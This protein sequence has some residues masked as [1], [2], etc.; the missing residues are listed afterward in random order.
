MSAHAFIKVDRATFFKFAQSHEGRCEYVRGRIIMQ[1]GGTFDHGRIAKR[2]LKLLD[3]QL[4]PQKWFASGSDR[5]VETSVTVRYPDVTVE[6]AGADPGSLFTQQ[7]VIAIEVL[8]PS[9][10]ERDL[11]I[12]PL[13]YLA[14]PTLQAYIVAA[15]DDAACLVWLR[16]DDGTFP[17]EP[18]E[19]KGHA[20]S[21]HV[22]ALAVEISLGDVYRGI[23]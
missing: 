13:E 8:S 20:A 1:Q 19:V 18:V 21:I 6:I 22:P 5:G 23:C 3:E 11:D 12:K 15:H 2:F 14:L 16:G 4:D 9:S 7:P 17:A 10:E